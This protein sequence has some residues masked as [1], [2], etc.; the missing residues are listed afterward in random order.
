MSMSSVFLLLRLWTLL[1]LSHQ[2]V[3]DAES[4]AVLQVQLPIYQEAH[5]AAATA[6]MIRGSEHNIRTVGFWLLLLSL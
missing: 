4:E 1:Q 5:T 6:S 3:S 2:Q